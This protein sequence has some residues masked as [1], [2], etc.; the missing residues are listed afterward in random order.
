MLHLTMPNLTK[1]KDKIKMNETITPLAAEDLQHNERRYFL[2]IFFE[3]SSVP[4][5]VNLSPRESAIIEQI[6]AMQNKQPAQWTR[7]VS[8]KCQTS[9]PLQPVT[10]R[11]LDALQQL[12]KISQWMMYDVADTD[13]VIEAIKETEPLTRGPSQVE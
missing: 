6:Q 1:R 11:Y 5:Y 10:T 13:N 9:T 8:L 7:Q 12:G 4:N 3:S 2:V